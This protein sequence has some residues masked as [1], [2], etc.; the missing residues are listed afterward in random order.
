MATVF[1]P[2]QLTAIQTTDRT[3]LLSAAA[4]SGKTATLTERLIRMIT[5]EDEPLDVSR[6]L[7]ATF[8]RA[9]AE[10][11]RERIRAALAD[12][13]LEHPE[14]RRLARQSLLLP[15]A[16]IRTIDAF[17]NDI[18]RGHTEALDIS[19]LYRILDES[20]GK[21]LADEMMEELIEDAYEGVL[22]APA[23]DIALLAESFEGVKGGR[24]L[25]SLLTEL[26]RTLSNYPKGVAL[27]EEHAA[28]L[29]REATLPF[30]E[31]RAGGSLC[32]HYA[33]LFEDKAT[34][35]RRAIDGA[36]KS[37]G[38]DGLAPR[39]LGGKL[40]YLVDRLDILANAARR[41]YTELRREAAL[42]DPPKAG[43]AADDKLSKEGRLCK[44]AVKAVSDLLRDLPQA[45]PW[46]EDALP[47]A[48]RC[49]ADITRAAY[50][51]LDEFDRRFT[52]E[53]R[54]RA[55]CDYG[56]LERYA[57]R[58]LWD[59]KGEKTPLAHS[60]AAS[61]DLVSID[62]YQDV[63]E[64]QHKIFEAVS[65][66]RDLFM[67]GDIKQSIYGFRGA[68][69][70]IFAHLRSTFPALTENASRAVLFLT[71][72][73][74]SLPSVL[75]LANGVFDFLFPIFGD[76]IGYREEDRLRPAREQTD[77]PLPSLYLL[78]PPP[79]DGMGEEETEGVS[80][81]ELIARKISS[82]LRS[83][84]LSDGSPIAPR[85]IAVLV[86][87]GKDKLASLAAALRRANVPVTAEDKESFFTQKEILLALCLLHSVS[88]PRR[89][90]Y[91]SGLLRSPLYGFT[92][93][94]LLAFRAAAPRSPLFDALSVY[95][96]RHPEREDVHVFLNELTEFRRLA[97]SEPSDRLIRTLFDKTG[98]YATAD[99]A[100]RTRLRTLA[101]LAGRLE[102]SDFHGLY[103]FLSHVSEMAERGDTVT[104]KVG[105]SNAVT[106]C[107]VHGSKGLEYPVVILSFL[108]AALH[109]DP[110]KRPPF[111]FSPSLGLCPDIRDREGL[112]VL[113]TPLREAAKHEAERR[114][115]AEEARVLYVAMTRAKEQCYLFAKPRG[116]TENL[117]A[118]AALLR[119]SP[120]ESALAEQGS[121]V[122]WI[123][124]ALGTDP[125]LCRTK[126]L[127]FP[128]DLEE[129]DARAD[130]KDTILRDAADA[131]DATNGNGDTADAPDAAQDVA[132][133][134]REAQAT[135]S[136]LRAQVDFVYPYAAATRL[137]GKLS[138][139][140]LYPGYL[141]EEDK[142]S[143]F[144]PPKNGAVRV[145]SPDAP[146]TLP[147]FLSGKEENAAAAAGTATHLFLQ[148]CDFNRILTTNGLHTD[149]AVC[150]ELSRLT[151]LGFLTEKDAARVRKEEIA[152]LAHSALATE[153]RQ[154][155]DVQR[156]LRFN[157]VLPATLL[158]TRE[159]ERYEGY[160]VLVQGVIDLLLE[161]KDG[162]LLLVDY[163]TDR[164]PPDVLE[165]EK[166]AAA[167]LFARH[168][169]QLRYYAL[170][171]ERMLGRFP[172]L[173]VYSLHAGRLLGAPT[174]LL[175]NL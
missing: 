43:G 17:C 46:E 59:E 12:A 133:R 108:G 153:L 1:T 120:S 98:I 125:I 71:Q 44:R 37:E 85:D 174:D 111:L 136:R 117:T 53:K 60:L 162:S 70:D 57:Y 106:L 55:V 68:S 137:P 150:E 123:L 151:K 84:R 21:L 79:R 45:L 128:Y 142:E 127:P 80:E 29:E 69:P 147:S 33:R 49:S 14:N 86:R 35:L 9:A 40:F 30:H 90:V 126:T 5:R 48:F 171:A 64:L 102:S 110:T 24:P 143:L 65:T 101:T 10:E 34:L 114:E 78:E 138:V 27:L 156:E 62:E 7:V 121:F 130:Q 119:L 154:A 168:G 131:P 15:S 82:L 73:F 100:G 107:T 141:D 50:L 56:D 134:K 76:A 129:D 152:R 20:E 89:D 22:S 88:N 4:G 103:R 18:V 159:R 175:S 104:R 140:A 3:V 160:S 16:R 72:N 165:S 28:L 146:L 97:E 157:T 63:N 93:E 51:M 41:S 173:A 39:A 161:R 115:L 109:A 172:A 112:A 92:M 94:D 163:K 116:K 19:P 6:M 96:E 132:I 25:A 36:L 87:G 52:T 145:P 32:A 47:Y 158:S 77:A 118:N 144:A 31:T 99:S 124:A 83:G 67:V 169:E 66:E 105:G 54:R 23:P 148:F 139:S 42:F 8:T 166:A 149:V 81:P 38:A 75:A 170:A 11:L 122:S 58:L 164:L 74:R 13:I 61:F 91:L 26:Y 2:E 113:K 167:L 95:A 135:L 155:R